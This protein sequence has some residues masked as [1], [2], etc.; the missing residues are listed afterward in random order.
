MSEEVSKL[1][2]PSWFV[3]FFAGITIAVGVTIGF[4]EKIRLP[5][6]EERLRLSE[7]NLSSEQT[8]SGDLGNSNTI[9]KARIAAL[10]TEN[11]SA[12]E[13]VMVRTELEKFSKWNG[14]WKVLHDKAVSEK[15]FW[16]SRADLTQQLKD[17][18]NR[19]TRASEAVISF[20]SVQCTVN[21]C[22]LSPLGQR[23]L[24]SMEQDRDHLQAQ[25]MDL[26]ARLNK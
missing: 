25:V 11:G 23:T 20:T 21:N 1:G 19:R 24:K 26:Q 22:D 4:Y 2:A 5:A 9:Y 12:A 10:T 13:L 18:A 8:R 6:L 7:E 15:N 14:E 16:Q 3:V 17:V